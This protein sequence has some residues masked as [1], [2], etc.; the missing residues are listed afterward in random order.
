MEWHCVRIAEEPRRICVE[1][2]SPDRICFISRRFANLSFVSSLRP[3]G[4]AREAC[5]PCATARRGGSSSGRGGSQRDAMA[6]EMLLALVRMG[7]RRAERGDSSPKKLHDLVLAGKLA[8]RHLRAFALVALEGPISVSELADREGLAV[9][10]ASLLVTQLADAGV[11]ERREDE[12]D[13]RRTLVSVAPAH[14]KESEQVLESLLAPLRR[15]FERLGPAA[16]RALLD[17]MQVVVSEMSGSPSANG[18]ASG[19]SGGGAAPKVAAAPVRPRE[20]G[21]ARGVSGGE[22]RS[23]T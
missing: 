11:V 2:G 6:S 18:D 1:G 9:S 10:T 13:R 15:A 3:V 14:R 20:R 23:V 8:P 4:G 17:G 22:R 19:S 5:A 21:A 12:C 16:G 7:G